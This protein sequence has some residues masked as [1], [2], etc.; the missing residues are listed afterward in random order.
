[1]P[2]WND[3]AFGLAHQYRSADNLQARQAL[4]ERFGRSVRPWFDAALGAL[5]AEIAGR[6]ARD[7]VIR[8]VRQSG[9]FRAA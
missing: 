6:L 5:R 2:T 9:L 8:I 3:P 7:G 4:H 1:M